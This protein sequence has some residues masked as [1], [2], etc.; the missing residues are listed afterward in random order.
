MESLSNEYA[1]AAEVNLATLEMLLDQKG[2]SME[3]IRR[4]RDICA[5]MVGVCADHRHEIQF[6]TIYHPEFPRVQ[7]FVE[8]PEGLPGAAFEVWFRATLAE[9]R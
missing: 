9:R 3:K 2:S 4:Q 5:R 1:W 6:G 8:D 7:R